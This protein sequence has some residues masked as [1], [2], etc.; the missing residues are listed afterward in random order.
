[1]TAIT[2]AAETNLVLSRRDGAVARL[3]LNDPGGANVLS[4]AMIA[5]LADALAAAN[6]DAGAR[7][8]VLDAEGRVFCAGHDLSEM[9]ATENKA[10]HEAL[11][12]ACSALM[13]AIGASP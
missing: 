3:T 8:V 5:A 10:D 2:V 7:V 12:S 13:L 6:A 11:F 1:M 4:S 9:R